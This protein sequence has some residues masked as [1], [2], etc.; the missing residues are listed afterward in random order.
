MAVDLE[1][2]QDVDLVNPQGDQ[3]MDISMEECLRQGDNMKEA[4]NEGYTIVVNKEPIQE[5]K[6]SVENNYSIE[7]EQLKL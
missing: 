3:E 4:G 7:E 6:M 2:H 1:N 5:N